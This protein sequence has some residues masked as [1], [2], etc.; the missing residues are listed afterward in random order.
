[1]KLLNPKTH[2]YIDY[3]AVMVFFLAP[4]VFGFSE[5]PTKI[6]YAIGILHL[7]LTLATAFPL[8]IIKAIPFT[9]HG[10]IEFAMSLFLIAL[11]WMADFTLDQSAQRFFV[12]FGLAYFGLWVVT[13]YKAE[14]V[15]GGWAAH[16][17]LTPR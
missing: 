3:L 5:Q 11:P 2:G 7:M 6:S 9:V 16:H 12:A 4:S 10:W 13:D 15:G 14:A 1:M 17:G 8:G